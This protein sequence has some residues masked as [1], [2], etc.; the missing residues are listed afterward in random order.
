MTPAALLRAR[1]LGV[2]SGRKEGGGRTRPSRRCSGQE[3]KAQLGQAAVAPGTG[4]EPRAPGQQLGSGH[5]S[6]T[7]SL[8]PPAFLLRGP[9]RVQE[10]QSKLVRSQ[11]RRAGESFCSCRAVG[12]PTGLVHKCHFTC[13]EC[14][15]RKCSGP[16]GQPGRV[17]RWERAWHFLGLDCQLR[18][19]LL[20]T[21]VTLPM[22]V[23]E[24]QS[25]GAG[26]GGGDAAEAERVGSVLGTVG[27]GA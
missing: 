15:L 9:T 2:W 23:E 22:H 19:S 20:A 6:F 5:H 16:M 18:R 21:R 1:L 8:I 14:H 3:P 13:A 4:S 27:G 10:G 25:L 26:G 11:G 12:Q 7:H 17:P 24:D